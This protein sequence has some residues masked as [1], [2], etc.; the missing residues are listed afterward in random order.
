MIYHNTISYHVDF[1]SENRAVFC[2]VYRQ[3]SV[4]MEA[5]WWRSAVL[6]EGGGYWL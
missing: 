3:I 5:A 2:I 1:T 6:C 4:A